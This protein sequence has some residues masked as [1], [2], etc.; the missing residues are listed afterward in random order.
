MHQEVANFKCP[1]DIN[2]GGATAPSKRLIHHIPRCE[3]LK[4]RVGA[5][6]A[7]AI[8]LTVLRERCPQFGR[9]LTRLECLKQTL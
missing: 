3:K 7:D 9:W 6:A 1:E 2:E 5:P 8:G 4:V